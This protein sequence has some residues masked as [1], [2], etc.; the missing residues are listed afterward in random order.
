MSVIIIINT[1]TNN[2][3]HTQDLSD[4]QFKFQNFF[5]IQNNRL[6]ELEKNCCK[7]KVFFSEKRKVKCQ[8]STSRKL[9]MR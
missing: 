5:K 4:D 1:D 3:S 2:L 8:P 7:Y 9:K 6:E